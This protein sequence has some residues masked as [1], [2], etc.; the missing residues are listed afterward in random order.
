VRTKYHLNLRERE[1]EELVAPPASGTVREERPENDGP[2]RAGRK[3]RTE[4]DVAKSE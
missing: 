2:R 1:L 4:D 3:W